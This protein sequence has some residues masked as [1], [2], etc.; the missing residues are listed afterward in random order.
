MLSLSSPPPQPPVAQSTIPLLTLAPLVRLRHTERAKGSRAVRQRSLSFNCSYEEYVWRG[1][2]AVKNIWKRGVVRC[3]EME[4][5]WGKV[6]RREP[7]GRS[8]ATLHLPV[9]RETSQEPRYKPPLKTT[10]LGESKRLL[11]SQKWG[12]DNGGVQGKMVIGERSSIFQWN[13]GCC[14]GEALVWSSKVKG[15]VVWWWGQWQ[16]G[17][18]RV[19]EKKRLRNVN[20]VTHE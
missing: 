2:G 8:E 14:Q 3:E 5:G 20:R 11:A 16:K 17:H 9:A 18:I 15:S 4:Q 1:G 13:A 7:P 10:L 6:S 12:Q 19:K